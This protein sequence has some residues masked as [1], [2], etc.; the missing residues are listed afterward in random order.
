MQA[1]ARQA[2]QE[3]SL[4]PNPT[5]THVTK[6]GGRRGVAD[7]TLTDPNLET[8]LTGNRLACATASETVAARS[9]VCL[10][11]CLRGFQLKQPTRPD[12]TEPA[13]QSKQAAGALELTASK[14]SD[15]AKS[16]ARYKGTRAAR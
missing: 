11:R 7:E 9:P 6:P 2:L 16:S 15:I 1:A 4:H 14:A 5:L 13:Q 10:Q 3:P 8:G 12:G